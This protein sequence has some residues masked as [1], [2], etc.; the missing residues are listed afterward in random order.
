MRRGLFYRQKPKKKEILQS[1]PSHCPSAPCGEES[2]CVSFDF[3]LFERLRFAQDNK[4]GV[5]GVFLEQTKYRI[6]VGRGDSPVRGNVC[7]ADKRVP[8]FGEFCSRPTCTRLILCVGGDDSAPRCRGGFPRPP[9]D[10]DVILPLRHAL[11]ACH[12]PNK[13]GGLRNGQDRSLWL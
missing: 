13:W 11:C 5:V 9:V 7:E 2:C 3:V 6:W 8:E 12:L 4:L 1:R 10:F